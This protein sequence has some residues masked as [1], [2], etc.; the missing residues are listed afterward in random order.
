MPSIAKI[1]EDNP[2]FEFVNKQ[3][4]FKGRGYVVTFKNQDKQVR[5]EYYDGNVLQGMGP[6]LKVKDLKAMLKDLEDDLEVWVCD[7]VE[8]NNYPLSEI[9]ESSAGTCYWT[10]EDGK[11][12]TTEGYKVYMVK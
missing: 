6:R 4:L 3:K 2:D 12:L 10:L 5:H 9:E 8:G 7:H 1:F 11:P